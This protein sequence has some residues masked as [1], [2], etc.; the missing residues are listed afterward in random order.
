[1]SVRQTGQDWDLD[2]SKRTVKSAINHL[3]ASTPNSDNA[4][5]VVLGDLLLRTVEAMQD[6]PDDVDPH[7]PYV[8][9][10]LHRDIIEAIAT[11]MEINF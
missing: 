11:Q 10:S 9:A 1:M 7:D 5:L 2:R 8:R 4:I 6:L 3:I